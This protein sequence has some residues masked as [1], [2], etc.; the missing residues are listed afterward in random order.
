LLRFPTSPEPL[1]WMNC[2]PSSARKKRSLHLDHS[3]SSYPLHIELG[4]GSGTYFRGFTS[5][6]G[7]SSASQAVLQWCLSSL[8]YFVLWSSLRTAPGQSR[9]LHRR[10][11]QRRFTSLLEASR[12]PISVF[13][14]KDAFVDPKPP[15]VCLLL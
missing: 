5:L 7:A 14:S 11:G 4:C 12:P 10:G 3:R 13:L 2:T 15:L 6:F 1:N 9:D 8:R